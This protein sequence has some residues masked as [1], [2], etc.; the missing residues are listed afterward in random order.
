M[1]TSVNK[2][3][4]MYTLY[5]ICMG[6]H[7]PTCFLLYMSYLSLVILS[8]GAPSS[9]P[10][11]WSHVHY[12]QLQAIDQVWPGHWILSP[13]KRETGGNSSPHRCAHLD[14]S[15]IRRHPLFRRLAI[16]C[17]VSA[18]VFGV[19]EKNL[20]VVTFKINQMVPWSPSLQMYA[21]IILALLTGCN[22]PWRTKR[23]EL[24][25]WQAVVTDPLSQK[26]FGWQQHHK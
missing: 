8:N 21:L 6:Q 3:T 4:H 10:N 22:F 20:K 2:C 12:P 11:A 5:S 24:E 19:S 25:K 17:S 13:N 23:D 18:C 1:Y 9:S 14:L 26:V 7:D 15:T 16:A